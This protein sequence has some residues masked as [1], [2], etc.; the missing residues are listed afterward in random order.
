MPNQNDRRKTSASSYDDMTDEELR[1]IL[2]SD[3]EKAE[4]DSTDMEQLLCIMEELAK[5]SKIRNEA[6]DP[7]ATWKA[8]KKYYLFNKIPAPE[9]H[10]VKGRRWKR[11]LVAAAAAVALFVGGTVVGA[12]FPDLFENIAKWTD[13]TFY[14]DVTEQPPRTGE[15]HKAPRDDYKDLQEALTDYGITAQLVPTWIPEGY[16][17]HEVKV[18]VNNDRRRFYAGYLKDGKLINIEI[19]DCLTESALQI[20]QSL[21]NANIYTKEGVAYYIF[22]NLEH[23]N[24]VWV[25]EGFE[26]R[27]C[28]PVTADEIENMID[29]ITKG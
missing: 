21:S 7:K 2:R 12:I 22:P 4:C 6:Q 18:H 29:S 9:K 3:A 13:E 5:R 15:L 8:F 16:E 17:L 20:H 26:C 27:I 28:G 11:G 25:A 14:F 19:Q 1:Q 10:P 24:A 23:L